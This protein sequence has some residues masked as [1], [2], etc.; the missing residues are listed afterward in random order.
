ME[1]FKSNRS[2]CRFYPTLP[3]TF[4]ILKMSKQAPFTYPK[5]KLSSQMDSGAFAKTITRKFFLKKYK[6]SELRNSE[7]L[8]K[9]K[10]PSCVTREF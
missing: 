5:G 4:F 10:F 8:M 2:F 7:F 6:I 9:L 1:I 3:R